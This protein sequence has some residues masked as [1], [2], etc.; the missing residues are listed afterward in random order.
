MK[1]NFMFFLAAIIYILS[2][3]CIGVTIETIHNAIYLGN[4]SIKQLSELKLLLVV[5]DG[6]VIFS[7]IFFV[8]A[9]TK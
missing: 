1:R 4:I 5:S 8:K 2:I 6:C 9:V 7:P 3:V